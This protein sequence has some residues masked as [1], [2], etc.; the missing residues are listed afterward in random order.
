MNSIIISGRLVADPELRF[1]A[2]SG[3]AVCNF[4]LAVDREYKKDEADFF[5]IVCFKKTAE[6]VA[7]FLTKGRKILIN[8]NL[9][10][11]NYEKADGTKVYGDHII[12]N[13]IEFLD[14]ADKGNASPPPKQQPQ[15]NHSDSGLG[16]GDFSDIELDDDVPF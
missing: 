11:N 4:K 9:Q 10:N 16:F 1:V 13:R 14:Y 12:A 2:G 5:R 3:M 8:G 15:N 6:N 7:N